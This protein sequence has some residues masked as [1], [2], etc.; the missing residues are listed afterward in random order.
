MNG[1][2]PLISRA[3]RLLDRIEALLQSPA[4][5]THDF[6]AAAFRWRVT[7]DGGSLAPIRRHAAARL[8]DLLAIDEQKSA[9]DRN[10]RQFLQGLPANHALLWGP[11]GTGKSS[12]VKALLHAYA[13]H[14]LRLIEIPRDALASLLD[15]VDHVADRAERFVIFCDDLSFDAG[16]SSYHVLKAC[17]DGS[18]AELP[19]NVLIYATSNRRHLLPEPLCDNDDTRIAD[20]EIHYGDAV[21]DRLSLAERFGISLAFHAMRQD[22]YLAIVAH[23]LW[24]LGV[25]PA[26]QVEAIRT[27]AL[28]WALL[29]GSRSG[30]CARQFARDWAGKRLV[31]S[32]P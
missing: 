6:T 26:Q 12:L 20:G 21:E 3:E 13:A 23:W 22:E 32:L 19:E 31:G 27:E 10:T 18:I 25:D 7:P 29:R 4:P 16:D 5:E 15:I 30:R 9:L 28:R 24:R 11:R 2:N 1:S 17:L 8:D 14:G